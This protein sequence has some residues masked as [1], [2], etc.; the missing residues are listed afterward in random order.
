M[1]F[2]RAFSCASFNS[3]KAVPLEKYDVKMLHPL[4]FIRSFSARLIESFPVNLE[5]MT[6]TFTLCRFVYIDVTSQRSLMTWK[7]FSKTMKLFENFNKNKSLRN[8]KNFRRFELRVEMTEKHDRVKAFS[9]HA[10]KSFHMS[11]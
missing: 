2:R 1:R 4:S 7:A 5:I 8:N 11:F 6:V 9:S 3:T 10:R